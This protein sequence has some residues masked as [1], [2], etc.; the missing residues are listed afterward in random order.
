MPTQD[1]LFQPDRI[2]IEGLKVETLIGVYDWEKTTKQT[3]FFD[4][5]MDWDIGQAAKADKVDMTLD[6]AAVS[7]KVIAFVETSRF[8]LIET[9][10]EGVAQLIL[11]EF[12]VS[13][14]RVKLQKPGAVPAARTVG[15]DIVRLLAQRKNIE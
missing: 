10:A 3:L 2:F 5:E 8:D 13:R 11:N 9:M 6:Y 1:V 14:V 4:L 15:V 7:D 12:E